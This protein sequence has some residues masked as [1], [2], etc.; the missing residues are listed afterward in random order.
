MKKIFTLLTFALLLATGANAQRQANPTGQHIWV[1]SDEAA[2]AALPETKLMPKALAK[3]GN[4]PNWTSL[5]MARYTEDFIASYFSNIDIY[6]YPVEVQECDTLSGFYRLVDPYGIAYPVCANRPGI[7]DSVVEYMYIHAENPDQVY[8]EHYFASGMIPDA[9]HGEM[10]MTSLASYRMFRGQ[11]VPAGEWGKL[12]TNTGIISFPTRTLLASA[13]LYPA[14][15]PGAWSYANTHGAFCIQLPGY[16]DFAFE[17]T[18]GDMVENP[19]GSITQRIYVH[20][21]TETDFVG[22]RYGL[23]SQSDLSSRLDSCINTLFG[24]SAP[25]TI[26]TGYCDVTIADSGSNRI[27]IVSVTANGTPANHQVVTVNYSPSQYWT[28]CGTYTLRDGLL[29]EFSFLGGTS[30]A[31]SWTVEVERYNSDPTRF[32][33]R[34]PYL[35]YPGT[36]NTEQ[37]YQGRYVMGTITNGT[38]VAIAPQPIGIEIGHYGETEVFSLNNGTIDT[39]HHE[40]T[41]PANGL[42]MILPDSSQWYANATST[43]LLAKIDSTYNLQVPQHTFT[44]MERLT[45]SIRWSSDYSI[46]PNI[47]SSNSEVV[48]ILDSHTLFAANPGTATIYLSYP[49]RP[50]LLAETDSIVVTVEADTITVNAHVQNCVVESSREYDGTNRCAIIAAGVL[51]TIDPGFPDVEVI[52]TAAFADAAIGSG[53]TI[54]IRYELAGSDIDHYRLLDSMETRTNGVITPKQLAFAQPKDDSTLVGTLSNDRTDYVPTYSLYSY[55]LTQQIYPASA[56]NHTA[57]ELNAIDFYLSSNTGIN[58]N[59]QIWVKNLATANFGNEAQWFAVSDNDLVYT[60][61]LTASQPGPIHIDFSHPVAYDGT[62]LLVM[63]HDTTGSWGTRY[64]Q[65]FPAGQNCTHVAYDDDAKPVL[66]SLLAGT[67]TGTTT[68]ANLLACASLHFTPTSSCV[69]VSDK[70]YDGTTAATVTLGPVE[71][72]VEGDAVTVTPTANF[73]DANMGIKPVVI[74][75]TLSGANAG[76]YLTPVND[77]ISAVIAPRPLTISGTEVAD[78]K[79]YDGSTECA[80]TPGTIGN[81]IAAQN[82]TLLADAEFANADK[83]LNKQVAVAYTLGLA[84]SNYLAP[85]NDTLTSSIVSDTIY[86]TLAVNDTNRGSLTPAASDLVCHIGDTLAPIAT[87]NSGFMFMYWVVRHEGVV[88]DTNYSLTPAWVLDYTMCDNHYSYT[89]VFDTSHTAYH[90]HFACTGTGEGSVS[91]TTNP[92]KNI[93]GLDL[94]ADS[95]EAITLCFDHAAGSRLRSVSVDNIDR[96]NDLVHLGGIYLLN[97]IATADMTVTAQFDSIVLLTVNGTSV[98]LNKVFDNND[99]AYINNNGTLLGVSAG[100][101]VAFSAEAH[102]SQ[103]TPGNNLPI[104]ITYSL[105]GSDANWY[106]LS[107]DQVTRYGSITPKQLTISGTTINGKTYDG[108]TEVAPTSRF[109]GTLEGSVAGAEAACVFTN[110]RYADPYVGSE[111]PVYVTY[112]TYGAYADCYLAPASDTL[113]APITSKSLSVVNTQVNANKVYDGTDSCQVVYDGRVMTGIVSGDTITVS[114][115]AHY[116]TKNAGSHVRIISTYTFGGPQGANYVGLNDSIHYGIISPM[117]LTA[118]GTEIQLAKEYDGTDSAVVLTGAML[119]TIEGDDVTPITTAFYDDPNV[120]HNK[121][122]TVQYA[123]AGADSANYICPEGGIY[124]TEGMIILPTIL[125]TITEAGDVLTVDAEGYCQDDNGLINYHIGQG[126]PSQYRLLFDEEARVQGFVNTNWTMLQDYDQILFAVPSNCQEGEYTVNVIFRNDA[127]VETAPIAVT[128]TVNLNSSHMVQ[129]YDDVVSIDNSLGRFSSYQWY[130][131]GKPING[132]TDPYYQEKGG[133]TGEYYVRVNIGMPDEARTC[134]HFFKSK[135]GNQAVLLYPNPVTTNTK[136]KLQGFA[137]GSHLM[138][139]FNA[140]GLEVMTITFIGT[141]Y[142]LD[143]SRLPQ[144]TYMVSV[145]GMAAKAMKY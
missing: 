80:V 26:T 40:V 43:F 86:V 116:V 31:L 33:V 103:S 8:I 82:V 69:V 21:S 81:L 79:I 134:E 122:I 145:D 44:L 124:S 74:S 135:G 19:N 75:Y 71:G 1:M 87:P 56:I 123:L 55:S 144:G 18:L 97:C 11:Q 107:Q 27:L 109:L 141:E 9:N 128:F 45:D 91:K 72:L 25:A 84:D 140:Y 113:A 14:T 64:F 36:F 127:N 132:A 58:R 39:L 88:I 98:A 143:M 142:S 73:A 136:V 23:F 104:V 6:T 24:S 95:A 16:P 93:C 138:K 85:V 78:Y 100:D 62:N 139:V 121:T 112:G 101:I 60:G 7:Y 102:Y 119:E 3:S 130:K 70:V 54:N 13:A 2:A 51:D 35:N 99:T 41:F 118:N 38:S 47:T 77:T 63:M 83:G 67:Y 137:D 68:R 34:N 37:R 94:L 61:S 52:A 12:D 110:V 90:I 131:D 49:S 46:A 120:G 96:T 42:I 114:A 89:A 32:R 111:K 22:F 125:D 48:R 117:P 57:G 30:S 106:A 17:N 4:T 10:R 133:L 92:S 129:L 76:N 105:S 66:D 53:K 108:T 59:V 20:P 28:S 126:E 65:S 115:K 15:N 50:H 5:G 29:H